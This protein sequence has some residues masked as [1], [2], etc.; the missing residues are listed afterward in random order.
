MTSPGQALIGRRGQQVG[1]GLAPAPP[2]NSE[3]PRP[4]RLL[5]PALHGLAQGNVRLLRHLTPEVKAEKCEA[6]PAQV[7]RAKRPSSLRAS[8]SRADARLCGRPTSTA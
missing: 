7:R 3:G 4:Q 5:H 1:C 8:G 2:A 6:V